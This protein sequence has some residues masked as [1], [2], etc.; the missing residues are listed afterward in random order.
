M[1]KSGVSRGAKLPGASEPPSVR[2]VSLGHREPEDQLLNFFEPGTEVNY[3]QDGGYSFE[4]TVTIDPELTG[5]DLQ[6]IVGH[7]GQHLV[8]AEAFASTFTASA[9]SVHWDL[10]KNLTNQQTETNAYEITLKIRSAA[11]APRLFPGGAWLGRGKM[12]TGKVRDAIAKILGTKTYAGKLQE[13]QMP[14][15]NWQP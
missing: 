7:E 4:A 1:K 6:A 13:L 9:D 10:S 5:V 2:S 15:Y 11:G 12:S 3:N 8:D 14:A